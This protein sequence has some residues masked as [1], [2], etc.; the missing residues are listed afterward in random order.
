M[1]T[2]VIE[3]GEKSGS[4]ITANQA[5]EEGRNVLVFPGDVCGCSF[6]GSNNLI[7]NGAYLI[8]NMDDICQF[9]Y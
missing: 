5:L 6:I 7:K 9:F 4:L 3:A 8:S 1:S 2:L